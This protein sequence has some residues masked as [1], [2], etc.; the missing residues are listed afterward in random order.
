S[1]LL[2]E[3]TTDFEILTTDKVGELHEI[4]S[5]LKVDIALIDLLKPSPADIEVLKFVAKS[6]PRLPLLVMTAFETAEIETALKSIGAIRYFEKPVDYKV[7]AGKLFD[8]IESTVG[9]VI[10]GIS[11]ASFLQMSEMERTSCTLRI[12]TGERK[13]YLFLVKG[14]LIA[15]EVDDLTGE[16]AVFEILSWENPAIEIENATPNRQKNISAPLMTLLMEGLKRKDEKAG[17]KPKKAKIAIQK[18]K[19]APALKQAE[20]K[21]V[22]ETATAEKAK[23]KED[24][25]GKVKEEAAEEGVPPP[26]DDETQ[27]AAAEQIEQLKA[28]GKITDASKVIKRKRRISLSFK[29]MV[30]VLSLLIIATVWFFEVKP[31][32]AKREYDQVVASADKAGT[33]AEK[34]A[35][36]DAY[37]NTYPDGLLTSKMR[38][39][40]AGLAGELEAQDFDLLVQKVS[41]LP[42]DDAFEPQAM[43]LYDA[44]LKKYPDSHY[45]E[46][47][48]KRIAD[49]PA[50]MKD[51]EYG[52]LKQIP[53]NDF[54]ARMAAYKAY[55]GT[56]PT[57][58]NTPNVRQML[59]DLGEDLYAHI[60]KS[61]TACD[62]KK[63]WEEC[64]K[65]CRYF[66]LHFPD[67]NRTAEVGRLQ[68]L[69]EDNA[70]LEALLKEVKAVGEGSAPAKALYV[71]FLKTRPGSSVSKTV[72]ARLSAI[73]S[74]EKQQKEWEQLLAYVQD[75][76]KSIFDRAA[77]MRNYV[78]GNPPQ[79]YRKEAREILA[80]LEKEE[81]KALQDRQ[82]QQ[83]MEALQQQKQ[84]RLNQLR[85]DIRQKLTATSGRYVERP[86]DCVFDAQTKLTWCMLDSSAM[87]D[88][89]MNYKKAAEYVK[90]LR[91]GGYSDWRL[92]KPSELLA[93]YNDRPAFPT[94]D[95]SWYWTSEVFSA[96][97]QERVNTVRKTATG[98]WEKAE[99]DLEQC[100]AVRAVRP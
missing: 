32:L 8:E 2:T 51:A 23:K 50:I 66:A 93:I 84:A 54:S 79:I 71:E 13:G 1:S 73:T 72:E 39:E 12:K 76:A 53:Q 97:W 14:S 29:V 64:I 46:E 55:I 88:Q 99:T 25:D 100:G 59:A 34:L 44:Y 18:A 69:M 30:G 92:P 60:L 89:C 61:K 94:T 70:A 80:W 49:I 68:T 91:T 82:Q 62:G 48:R 40:R 65:I 26:A 57:G 7:L 77:R 16:E 56:Y 78:A 47:V 98:M 28:S 95:T 67:H 22:L 6:H 19:T 15:A 63:E 42:I 38:E 31:W 87:T 75:G 41:D 45:A 96:A 17:K 86:A 5:K 85:A 58:E 52:K 36:V 37:I 35:I 9:G 43:A 33:L 81:A 83:T 11:L 10:Q 27:K 21:L 4:A 90:N 3:H 24:A 74:R 20:E